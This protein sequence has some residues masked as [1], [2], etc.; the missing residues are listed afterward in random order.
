MDQEILMKNVKIS[1]VYRFGVVL[2]LTVLQV[3]ENK[4]KVVQDETIGAESPK[5]L[6]HF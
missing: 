3:V 6:S 4:R 2:A 5:P 1:K